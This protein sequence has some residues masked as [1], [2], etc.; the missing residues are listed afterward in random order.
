[1]NNFIDFILLRDPL[2]R[3]IIIGV[4]LLS[5]SSSIVGVFTFLRKRALVGDA[6]SHAVLPGVCL[7]F[8]VQGSK[9]PFGLLI[10]AFITGWISLI[11]IDVI[12]SKTRLKEDTAIGIVLTAFFAF[13]TVLMSYIQNNSISANQG[14]LKDFLFGSV[15]SIREQDI[16]VFGGVAVALIITSS[17][18]FKE[19]FILSFDEAFTKTIGF[20]I[21]FLKLVLTTLTV[22]AV[23]VGIQAVG[24]VLMAAMLI[25]PAAAARFWTDRLRKMLVI[26]ASLS[27]VSSLGGVY[28]SY[29]NPSPTGP[30]MVMILSLIALISF[31]ISPKKGIISKLIRQKRFRNQITKENILKAIYQINEKVDLPDRA[32]S[33]NEIFDN[34]PMQRDQ[35]AWGLKKLA[36]EG[37][38]D[39]KE[40]K[41]G[42]TN[43]GFLRGQRLTKLHRLWELYL[44]EKMNIAPDHVHED[45]DT[46]EHIITPELE[47]KLE[48]ILD[49]PLKDPHDSIIPYRK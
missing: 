41:W 35:I 10:G 2:V 13:G 5:I 40:D 42:F 9:N 21:I 6:V 45:A 49:Y 27:V 18:L 30:W 44:T 1:M 38:L 32:L 3:N 39:K 26:A 34:R 24:V 20:P 22:F 31:L 48:V 28:I 37:F 7:A 33:L 29:E 15:T 16:Y 11:C 17:L 19:F 25:T 12:T 8:I 47:A 23:V 14:G 4:I 43:E 36:Q 46:I